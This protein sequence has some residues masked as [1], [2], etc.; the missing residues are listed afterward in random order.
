M[1]YGGNLI[2]DEPMDLKMSKKN[3]GGFKWEIRY[4]MRNLKEYSWESSI[5]ILWNCCEKSDNNSIKILWYVHFNKFVSI[6]WTDLIKYIII[7][8]VW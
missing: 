3:T 6:H 5:S 8:K 4:I 2:L 1:E 7:Q